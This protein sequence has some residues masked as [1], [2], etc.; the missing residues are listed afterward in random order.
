MGAALQ[1][2]EILFLVPLISQ[3]FSHVCCLSEKGETLYKPHR[4]TD[5]VGTE[6]L[7]YLTKKYHFLRSLNAAVEALK[8]YIGVCDEFS[9]FRCFLQEGAANASSSWGIS[10]P[11]SAPEP[12]CFTPRGGTSG[13]SLLPPSQSPFLSHGISWQ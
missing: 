6:T 5:L 3:Y 13:F 9:F 10:D 4:E 12:R 2:A 7:V 11:H 1:Y 8:I